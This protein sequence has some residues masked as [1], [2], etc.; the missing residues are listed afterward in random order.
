[1]S[2]NFTFQYD[3]DLGTSKAPPRE[4]LSNLRLR[5]S[6]A[7]DKANEHKTLLDRYLP[8]EHHGST[9]G[10]THSYNEAPNR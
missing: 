1:M 9:I 6:L 4:S 10:V 3:L 5:A 7:R 2:T 8:A